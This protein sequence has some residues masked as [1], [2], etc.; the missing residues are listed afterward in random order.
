MSSNKNINDKTEEEN[1]ENTVRTD[2]NLYTLKNITSDNKPKE[3]NKT[4]ESMKEGSANN[5]SNN[6]LVDGDSSF[7]SY[8]NSKSDKNDSNENNDKSKEETSGPVQEKE[9]TRITSTTIKTTTIPVEECILDKNGR[10]SIQ[11]CWVLG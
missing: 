4:I 5:I 2:D 1:K 9:D 8:N 3:K 7:D 6:T 11:P 10:P